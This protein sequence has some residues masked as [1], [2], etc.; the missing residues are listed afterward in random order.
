MSTSAVELHR[1]TRQEY[2]HMIAAGVFHPEA[3]LELIDGAIYTVTPQGSEH[4]TAVQLVE[5]ALRFAFRKGYTIRTQLPL[6]LGESS[7]PEPDVA[8]VT[9]APRDY[10]A[11]HPT[12]AVLVVEVADT[13]LDFD[14][15]R[16]A[17]TY[18]RAGIQD[19]WIVNLTD[20]LVEVYRQPRE[21]RYRRQ[22]NVSPT[23][24]VQPLA[25]P[26]SSIPVADMLP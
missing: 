21:A 11:A 24:S 12:T 20:R 2:E 14:R 17:L 4:A 23:D 9:G 15:G 3:R 18:A 8:V 25:R 7:E 10:R 13:S 1:W 26:G 16:K 22:E 5:D 6:A 19:Y